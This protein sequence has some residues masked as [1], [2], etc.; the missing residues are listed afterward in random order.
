MCSFLNICCFLTIIYFIYYLY[1]LLKNVETLS[2]NA[3]NK[4]FRNVY[5]T[6]SRNNG[7]ISV[8]H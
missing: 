6:F 4:F 7:R 3:I 1:K 8:M 2:T 5:D